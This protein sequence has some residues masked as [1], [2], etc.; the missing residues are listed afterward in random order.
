MNACAVVVLAAGAGTR[1]RSSR[2]KVLHEAA[3]LP[4]LEHVLRAVDP[5]E[6]R[7]V[8]VVVGHL[9]DQV[10][11]AFRERAAGGRLVFAEQR[12]LLGT[13]HA[14]AQ[15]ESAVKAAFQAGEDGTVLVL[16][17]DGPLLRPQTLRRML[18]AQ[19]DAAGMSVLVASV[20]DPS[21]LGRVV[22]AGDSAIARIVEDKDADE[23]ERAIR[24]INAGAY[25]FDLGVFER[26]RRLPSDNAQGE[27][28]ITGLVDLYLEEGLPV[29]AVPATAAEEALAVND[30]EELAVVD[31]AL[32]GR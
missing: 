8:V 9:G 32:R 1:M 16:N 27:Q 14:L 15:A 5:L 13:G 7:R 12:E 19:G 29:R 30:Q 23:A 25:A 11:D 18:E 3:G 24:E 10:R 31:R 2:H 28:Y 22:R 6:A 21:G 4:L 20:T 26:C 17:G